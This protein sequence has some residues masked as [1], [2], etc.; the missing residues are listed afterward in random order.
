MRGLFTQYQQSGIFW[1]KVLTPTP[2]MLRY[3]GKLKASKN[4]HNLSNVSMLRQVGTTWERWHRVRRR[5]C[6]M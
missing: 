5:V 3:S 6:A 2:S 4:N 1:G